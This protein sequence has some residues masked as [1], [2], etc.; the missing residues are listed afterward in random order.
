MI[1]SSI[2]F[3]TSVSLYFISF[4]PA[5]WFLVFV[6]VC[7]SII[8]SFYWHGHFPFLLFI[9]NGWNFPGPTNSRMIWWRKWGSVR[10]VFLVSPLS[11]SLLL[12]QSWVV[13]LK[14]STAT[15]V[16]LHSP[17]FISF[18]PSTV[19]CTIY[20]QKSQQFPH[21]VEPP[22]FWGKIPASTLLLLFSLGSTTGLT[23]WP[24]LFFFSNWHD[25]ANVLFLVCAFFPYYVQV[26]LSLAVF[27]CLQVFLKM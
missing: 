12:L 3:L 27:V 17:C 11:L 19:P 7:A 20:Y 6:L 4:S 8:I 23:P 13:S 14:H 26:I 22:A 5:L 25:S 2:Y 1:F 21:E 24:S 9:L 15:S 18:T 10:V 16:S